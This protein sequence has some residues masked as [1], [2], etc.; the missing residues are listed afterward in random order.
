MRCLPATQ[1]KAQPRTGE[2]EKH[3]EFLKNL[4]SNRPV[5]ASPAVKA[6]RSQRPSLHATHCASALGVGYWGCLLFCACCFLVRTLCVC[7][8]YLMLTAAPP[9][10]P[11]Q[12]PF[13]AYRW[14][15]QKRYRVAW[16]S[17]GSL[18]WASTVVAVV[19]MPLYVSW[20]SHCTCPAVQ[21]P[22]QC[23]LAPPH[24]TGVLRLVPSMQG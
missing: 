7:D 10:S 24:P 8:N 20:V 19:L 21:P 13:P 16:C 15:L 2:Q 1:R 23:P 9:L 22:C 14:G 3:G 12:I 4:V 11:A 5:P 17:L 18:F 6:N